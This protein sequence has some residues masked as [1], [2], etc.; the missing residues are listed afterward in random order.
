ML[1]P[2]SVC[3]VAVSPA[4]VRLSLNLFGVGHHPAKTLMMCGALYLTV[5]RAVNEK[6]PGI[7][8]PGGI[9]KFNASNIHFLHRT[10]FHKGCRYRPDPA[11]LYRSA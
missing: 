1:P 6:R 10:N 7:K 4:R 11:I 2:Y 5:P 9:R 8:S 3:C